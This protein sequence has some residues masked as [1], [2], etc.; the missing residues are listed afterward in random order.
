MI[1]IKWVTKILS[2]QPNISVPV[3]YETDFT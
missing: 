1:Y 3:R 2:L